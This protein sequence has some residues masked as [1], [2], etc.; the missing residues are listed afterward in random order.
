MTSNTLMMNG[1]MQ[2]ENGQGDLAHA[3]PLRSTLEETLQQ[4]NIL[5]KENSDLKEALKH[6][7]TSMKGRF[8]DLASWK[9]KQKEERD[10]LEDKLQEAKGSV[11]AL[12]KRNE[13]QRKKIQMFEGNGPGTSQGIVDHSLE[14]EQLKAMITRLQAEKCDLVAMNSELQLKQRSN[15]PEDSFI[16]IRIAQEGELKLTKDLQNKPA[17][18]SA[19]Y[20][21]HK[22]FDEANTRLESEELTVSQLL[23]SLRLE[24]QKVEKLELELWAVK[25]RMSD[26]EKR[27]LNVAE[28]GTQTEVTVDEKPSSVPMEVEATT[29][30]E[31]TAE[32]QHDVP[33]FEVENLKSQVMSL[34]EDLQEA[35]SKLDE[36]EGMKKSLQARQVTVLIVVSTTSLDI[37][38]HDLEQDLSTLRAQLVKKQEVQYQNETLKLQVDSLQSMS[39]MEQMKTEDEKRKLIQLQ[40]AYAKLFEDYTAM[41]KATEEVK[42]NLSKE[43]MREV[44]DRLIAAEEALAVKQQKIDEMKQ[45]MFKQEQE[46][47]TVSLFKAQAD[48]YSS[49]FYAERAAREKIHEE[50]ERIEAQLEF[51]K[52]QNYKLQEEMESFGRQSLNEMQRRHVSRGASPQQNAQQP[53]VQGGARGAENRDWQQQVNIP[54]RACPK[55]NEILPDI[56]SLQIHVMDCII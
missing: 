5:I 27:K 13:E 25:E 14:V 45:Q 56:D 24:T 50:K 19:A 6:T 42:S 9:E 22:C 51:I 36:A 21:R 7:N 30:C 17:D 20:I 37:M 4:M 46:L 26:L 29:T 54:E 33:A 39:K 49:D 3:A 52:K 43:E 48:I 12:T 34:F 31:I 1:E 23:Q 18:P 35:H 38:C 28:S 32:T 53:N 15:S 41:V 8:E 40:D 11:A 16:E 47:E 2:R 10:F 55:C 44:N